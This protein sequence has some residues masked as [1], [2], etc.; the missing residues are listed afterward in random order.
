[1][2]DR[3]LADKPSQYVA[4][5]PVQLSLVNPS[6]LRGYSN[7]EYQRK[8]GT[9]QTQPRVNLSRPMWLRKEFVFLLG[10]F[11]LMDSINVRINVAL[12]DDWGFAT[13]SQNC[14]QSEILGKR[15]TRT[16]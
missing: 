15:Y 4:G 2:G 9:K 12:L 14:N 8:P 7:N 1:M 3:L 6:T 10:A 11:V 16:R 13:P 5:H